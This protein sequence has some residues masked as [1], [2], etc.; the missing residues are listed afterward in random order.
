MTPKKYFI[1]W[2]SGRSEGFITDCQHDAQSCKTGKP[3]RQLGYMSQSAV[4]EA[5]HEAYEDDGLRVQEIEICPP[6]KS[7]KKVDQ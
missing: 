5:F 7:R 4:G 1:V 3:H 6:R 2:N